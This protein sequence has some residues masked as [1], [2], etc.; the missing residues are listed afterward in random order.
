MGEREVAAREKSNERKGTRG[1][2]HGEQ[3]APG[4]RGPSWARLCWVGL[5]WATPWV[6]IPWHTQP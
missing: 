4:A 1:R 2:A 5:G 6:K 3:G